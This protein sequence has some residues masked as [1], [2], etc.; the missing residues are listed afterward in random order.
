MVIHLPMT[1][2]E[3]GKNEILLLIYLSGAFIFLLSLIILLILSLI[4]I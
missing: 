2:V 4:H 1:E 3:D